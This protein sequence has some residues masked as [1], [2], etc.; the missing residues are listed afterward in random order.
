[1]LKCCF[2]QDNIYAKKEN[3]F[4]NIISRKQSDSNTNQNF[5][6]YM[7]INSLVAL[8]FFLCHVIHVDI[9]LFNLKNSFSLLVQDHK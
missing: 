3:Q 9:Y 4:S 6:F 5:S 7:K 8:F 1:M 2:L